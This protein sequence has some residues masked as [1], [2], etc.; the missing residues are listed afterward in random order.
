MS[1]ET[2]ETTEV[3]EPLLPRENLTQQSELVLQ[4]IENYPAK[5]AATLLGICVAEVAE[6]E[7]EN[8]KFA[9]LTISTR[10]DLVE[11]LEV[12]TK[13][14]FV[15]T[16]KKKY[17]T[18]DSKVVADTPKKEKKVKEPK[19]PKE[20]KEKAPKEPKAPNSASICRAWLG[21]Q[22]D[23][24]FTKNIL[25]DICKQYKAVTDA[26]GEKEVGIGAFRN[27]AIEESEKRGIVILKKEAAPKPVKEPKAPKA[28]A[29][30]TSETPVSTESTSEDNLEG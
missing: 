29:T 7:P 30:E 3:K 20:K 13:L 9:G 21:E 25:T 17:Y 6:E 19:T 24:L 23:E 5:D 2:T 18:Y 12:L 15:K 22:S 16:A 11:T 28:E 8:R 26:N 14:G 27:Y 4:V 10:E 1:N